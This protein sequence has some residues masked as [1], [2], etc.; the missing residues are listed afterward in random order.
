MEVTP[1]NECYDSGLAAV[2]ATLACR[3]VRRATRRLSTSVG[4]LRGTACSSAC[5]GRGKSHRPQSQARAF[6]SKW[7]GPPLVPPEAATPA[8]HARFAAA[9][10]HP[11]VS[12]DPALPEDVNAAA[13]HLMRA[14]AEGRSAAPR[15][16]EV[17]RVVKSVKRDLRATN[18]RLEAHVAPHVRG[19]AQRVD[20]ALYVDDG[21]VLA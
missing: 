18:E 15:R 17:L 20:I 5:S 6:P 16:N 3:A 19:M 8:Q 2:K 12:C 1:I 7:A 14:H 11:A 9:A 21:Y 13:R 10:A 4:R